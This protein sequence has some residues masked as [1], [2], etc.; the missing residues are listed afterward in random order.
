MTPSTDNIAPPKDTGGGNKR[1]EA[2]VDG[3]NK[4]SSRIQA[5]VAQGPTP[6]IAPP[7]PAAPPEPPPPPPSAEPADAIV[8][9]PKDALPGPDAA[10][11][12]LDA[13]LAELTAELLDSRSATPG[14]APES[15]PAQDLSAFEPAPA[16]QSKTA[17]TPTTLPSTPPS[18]APA[19]PAPAAHPSP[20]SPAAIAP[21][22]ATTPVQA[23]SSPPAKPTP[24][25]AEPAKAAAPSRLLMAVAS[26]SKPLA[27]RPA[28]VRNAAG[29]LA[30]NSLLLGAAVWAF[31]ALRHPPPKTVEQDYDFSS[32][33]LPA[34]APEKHEEAAPAGKE[35]AEHSE[36][37]EG[38]E[39]KP[40]STKKPPAKTPPK[41]DKK[42]AKKAPPKTEGHE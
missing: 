37:H 30:I 41:S 36:G 20:A 2:L 14:Q 10:I 26:L 31:V 7:P 38:A 40:K 17:P 3:I 35:G 42:G 13:Q 12:S 16:P 15:Q 5:A 1:I 23:P 9:P 34:P 21:A 25:R 22:P 33:K 11:E 18:H 6:G 19:Q 29:L 8:D 32:A 4:T 28:I 24:N 27:K 39:A